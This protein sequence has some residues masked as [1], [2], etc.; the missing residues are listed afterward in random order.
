MFKSFY[1]KDKI[2]KQ[3]LII[4]LI[5]NLL[6]W[7]LVYFRLPIQVEPIILRYNIYVGINLIGPWYQAYFLPLAGLVVFLLNFF[8]G[9]SVFKKDFLLARI[10]SLVATICQIILLFTAVLL[11]IV[12]S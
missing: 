6:L 8:I 5:L 12:N 1:F 7:L 10:L 3:N 11:A 9:R 4:G 2:I